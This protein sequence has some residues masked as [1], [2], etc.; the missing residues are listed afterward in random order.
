MAS[1]VERNRCGGNNNI[2]LGSQPHG[3]PSGT[4]AITEGE[5][6]IESEFLELNDQL[7]YSKTVHILLT[8]EF[9]FVKEMRDRRDSEAHVLQYESA[10]TVMKCRRSDVTITLCNSC[11]FTFKAK[12]NKDT[13]PWKTY[14]LCGKEEV[15]PKWLRSF[16]VEEPRGLEMIPSKSICEIGGDSD[17]DD[18]SE[19]DDG[20]DVQIP[21]HVLTHILAVD[22]I[23]TWSVSMLN[24]SRVRRLA[25]TQQ[26]RPALPS[27]SSSNASELEDLFDNL[28]DGSLH[29]SNSHPRLSLVKPFR[30]SSLPNVGDLENVRVDTDLRI[31]ECRTPGQSSV[32]D[33][34]LKFNSSGLLIREGE[35]SDKNVALATLQQRVEDLRARPTN[36]N[37][38]RRGKGDEGVWEAL[39][40]PRHHRKHSLCLAMGNEANRIPMPSDSTKS[41]RLVRR[42]PVLNNKQD[43]SSWNKK[44]AVNHD[45]KTRDLSLSPKKTDLT[46]NIKH[47]LKSLRSDSLPSSRRP[48]LSHVT[49]SVSGTENKSS[50]SRRLDFKD[51]M[52]VTL[53][54]SDQPPRKEK[55]KRFLSVLYKKRPKLRMQAAESDDSLKEN[56]TRVRNVEG[57]LSSVEDF[58]V[59]NGVVGGV[60]RGGFSGNLP[61]SKDK[62]SGL[63]STK[64]EAVPPLHT[65]QGM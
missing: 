64:E 37:F 59:P 40:T 24:P 49:H 52:A 1:D 22:T 50:A 8:D 12:W 58:G 34:N 35:S 23:S 60:R 15:W 39:T 38:V 27:L 10:K 36:L 42:S 56:D 5:V 17:S 53:S 43:S 46:R 33:P 45:N 62:N 47:S 61:A 2:N 54:E 63:V 9:V 19:D 48:D 18:C 11:P 7:H 41:S 25:I 51:D 55:V 13:S 30:C 31:H 26:R 3:L 14:E 57:N 20:E 65:K 29:R 21:E 28:N 6:L 16:N 4:S 32:D 44:I